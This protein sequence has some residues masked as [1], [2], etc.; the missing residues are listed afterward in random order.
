MLSC[1]LLLLVYL[2]LTV[3]H[4]HKAAVADT[5]GFYQLNISAVVPYQPK[6]FVF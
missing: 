3:R 4:K 6:C 5:R 2:S 1:P